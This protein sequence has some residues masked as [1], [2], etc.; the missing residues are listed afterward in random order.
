LDLLVEN[1]SVIT[2]DAERWVIDGGSWL[3]NGVVTRLSVAD[4][5]V[6]PG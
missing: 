6:D 4:V 2:M 5:R 1:A 3:S